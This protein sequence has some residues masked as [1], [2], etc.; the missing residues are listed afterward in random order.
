M[1]DFTSHNTHRLDVDE[2]VEMLLKLPYIKTELEEYSRRMKT[3]LV[4]GS[5]FIGKNLVERLK[6]RKDCQVCRIRSSDS[7]ER[8]LREALAGRHRLSIWPA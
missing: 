8:S 5:G 6:R 7:R 4:T 1:E 2:M 3:V